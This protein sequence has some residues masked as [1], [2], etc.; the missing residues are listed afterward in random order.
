MEATM[1]QVLR[2]LMFAT[3]VTA[4]APPATAQTAPPQVVEVKLRDGSVLVGTIVSDQRDRLVIKTI[5]GADVTMNRDQVESI[6]QTAGTS[7]GGEFWIDDV[8]ASKLFLGPTGRALKRG[9]GYFAIDSLLVPVFQVGVTDRFSIG[10]GAPFW[11]LVKTTWVTPKF[12]VYRNEKTAISAGVLHLF[13]P[14]FGLGGFGYVVATRGT[15]DGSVTFGGGMLYGH[16]DDHNAAGI[17]MFTVGGDR[18]LSRR[19]KFV[20]ENYI[21]REGVIATAG[22]RFIGQT[23]SFEIGALLPIIDS[24]ALPGFFFNFVFHSRPRASQK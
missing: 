4:I 16:D 19:T 21:F 8:V 2:I 9:E 20:T 13:V 1:R 10:L 23:T 22:A 12:Q 15:A 17:P 7:V 3:A 6:Q 24:G 18:R 14:D 5:S 11:G